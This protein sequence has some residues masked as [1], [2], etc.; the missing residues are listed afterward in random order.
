[1]KNQRVIEEI[2]KEQPEELRLCRCCGGTAEKH[3]RPGRNVIGKPGFIA[4]ISCLMCNASVSAFGESER[5]ASVMSEYYWNR[6][7]Y[8]G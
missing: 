8:D 5:E 4:V 3:I 1:M 2:E 7:I 6:G